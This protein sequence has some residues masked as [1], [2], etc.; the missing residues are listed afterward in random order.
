METTSVVKP[1]NSCNVFEWLEWFK[2]KYPLYMFS[3]F[4]FLETVNFISDCLQLNTVINRTGGSTCDCPP[5]DVAWTPGPNSQPYCSSYQ[6]IDGFGNEISYNQ[7]WI[8]TS[9]FVGTIAVFVMEAI[10][11][12]NKII[13]SI[14][15][16]CRSDE[17]RTVEQKV[18]SMVEFPFIGCVL[19]YF[20][21][22]EECHVYYT[23][24]KQR[25]EYTN[26]LKRVFGMHRSDYPLLHRLALPQ[27]LTATYGQTLL[28]PIVLP[29][30]KKF[31]QCLFRKNMWNDVLYTCFVFVA[32]ILVPF[33]FALSLMYIG[34]II[35]L[36]LIL[37][38]YYAD[39]IYLSRIIHD[40]PNIVM[41]LQFICTIKAERTSVFSVVFSLVLFLY[42]FTK[43]VYSVYKDTRCSSP[44]LFPL[45][46]VYGELT[47]KKLFFILLVQ[48]NPLAY[49]CAI[50]CLKN[51]ANEQE[52]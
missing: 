52:V 22:K 20:L 47:R 42:Y 4:M 3:F 40:F 9:L 30:T 33:Y 23:I 38:F 21:S 2:Y 51:I 24:N 36:V 41:T 16:L 34:I 6:C 44:P 27:S 45:D 32:L 28:Y 35:P 39:R 18:H 11:N 17:K 10:L 48:L 29:F 46:D 13:D 49:P 5:T 15:V 8:E 50:L 25:E 19:M 1:V 31:Y 43:M 14:I 7:Y 26:V 12:T 37:M